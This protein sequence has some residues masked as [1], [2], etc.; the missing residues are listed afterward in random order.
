MLVRL[1]FIYDGVDADKLS[2]GWMK[3]LTRIAPDA[4]EN[5]QKA[6]AEFS[7]LFTVRVKENDVYDITWMPNTGLEVRFN[8]SLLLV[9]NSL[10]FKKALF[11]IWI[12]EKP[13]DADLKVGMLGKAL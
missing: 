11:A 13:G 12:G 6:M 3:G 1:H 7:G 2:N 4:D 8:G 9:I 10:D 5:L